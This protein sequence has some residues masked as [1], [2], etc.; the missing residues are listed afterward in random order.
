MNSALYSSCP[1]L[2]SSGTGMHFK[3]GCQPSP[4]RPWF[5]QQ[6][7]PVF[8]FGPVGELVL[9]PVTASRILFSAAHGGRFGGAMAMA[10]GRIA[11]AVRLL[12]LLQ[13]L[14]LLSVDETGAS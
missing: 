6:C 7:I 2:I 12:L 11:G 14:R 3:H 8:R 1:R 4:R 13:L 10:P 5:G 9:R